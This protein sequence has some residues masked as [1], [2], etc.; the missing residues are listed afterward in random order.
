MLLAIDAGNTNI[1]FAVHDGADWRGRW[2]SA[3]RK[4][5]TSDEYAAWLLRLMEIEGI[6]PGDIDGAIIGSVVPGCLFDLKQ[7]CRDYFGS[8]A[9]VVGEPGV[10]LGIDVRVDRP[11]EVGADRLVNAVAAH[12]TY[13]KPVVILDFGT[14]TTF[15]VIDG[16]GAYRGGVIAPG[17][18]L[19]LETLHRAA[20]Q[21]PLVAVAR[22][23][24]VIGTDTVSAIQSGVYWGYI[25][26]IEG[27]LTR[28]AAEFAGMPGGAPVDVVATGGLAPLFH[29]ASDMLDHLDA[30]LTM[31]GLV[32]IYRRN[33]P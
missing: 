5:R 31:R 6:A 32:A 21:L 33:T 28:I 9:L 3:T 30:D 12:E 8:D 2:R 26:L 22:P 13:S 24:T 11:S 15:D 14:A 25:G 10:T 16:E 18:N 29:K 17:I 7:L 27:L 20:A 1:G 23:R 19:S 4:D